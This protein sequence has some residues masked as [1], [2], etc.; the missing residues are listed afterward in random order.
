MSQKKDTKDII[1]Q[2]EAQGWTVKL[3]RR[4]SHWKAMAPDGKG[5]VFFPG[6]PGGARSLANTKAELRKIGAIIN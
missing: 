4:N 3:T 2:L 6:T 5:M 1:R